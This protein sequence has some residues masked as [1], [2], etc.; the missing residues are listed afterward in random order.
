MS[1][2][3]SPSDLAIFF[4]GFLVYSLLEK[5][6]RRI[7]NAMLGLKNELIEIRKILE[8]NVRNNLDAPLETIQGSLS[9]IE[10]RLVELKGDTDFFRRITTHKMIDEAIR[11]NNLDPIESDN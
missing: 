7:E 9:S 1:T 3:I 2:W 4:V 5:D 11:N 8:R 6:L 10:N